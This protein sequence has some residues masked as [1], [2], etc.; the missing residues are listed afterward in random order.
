MGGE[1]I[2]ELLILVVRDSTRDC[3]KILKIKNLIKNNFYSS[4]TLQIYYIKQ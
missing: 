3:C 1:G 2:E 4:L